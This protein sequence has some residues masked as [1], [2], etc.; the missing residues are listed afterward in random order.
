MI[1]VALFFGL[2]VAGACFG[3]LSE[4]QQRSEQR[5]L[6]AQELQ[7][8]FIGSLGPEWREKSAKPRLPA[9]TNLS[10]GSADLLRSG[11]AP[12]TPHSTLQP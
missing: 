5:E 8:L 12:Q 10:E 4:Y 6:S 1:E 11:Q 2:I 9:D 3:Y 7:L